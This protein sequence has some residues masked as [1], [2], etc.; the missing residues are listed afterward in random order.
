ML[1][2]RMGKVFGPGY[3]AVGYTATVSS[4]DC[5][6]KAEEATLNTEMSEAVGVWVQGGAG[7]QGIF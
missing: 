6:S 1:K 4:H 7:C 5:H 2:L 3:T